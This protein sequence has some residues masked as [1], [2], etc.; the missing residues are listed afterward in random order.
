[1]IQ[2]KQRRIP[3]ESKVSASTF[4]V[5]LV[6]IFQY[7]H[8]RFVELFTESQPKQ[9]MKSAKISYLFLKVTKNEGVSE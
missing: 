9:S 6:V 4:K 1:M 7:D 8:T 2:Y 5:F 3:V